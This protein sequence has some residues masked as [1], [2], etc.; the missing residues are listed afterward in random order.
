MT[1]EKEA[2]AEELEEAETR[3]RH[4]KMQLDDMAVKVAEQD[5]TVM[6]LVDELAAE[7]QLRRQEEDA[8]KRSIK[9]VKSSPIDDIAEEDGSK[10]HQQT[11]RGSMASDSGFESEDESSAESVFSLKRHDPTSPCLSLSSASS[12]TWPE[13]YQAESLKITPVRE[14][15]KLRPAV[16]PQRPSTFQKASGLNGSSA[17]G[18][19]IQG[20]DE[21]L[22][23]SCANCQGLKASE[24]WNVVGILKEENKGLKERVGDLEGAVEG[25]LDLVAGL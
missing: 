5:S 24:A 16:P 25:C 4:L 19:S 20:H 8:R 6:N 11:N 7:K 9:L 15:A 1:A 12:T 18:I 21:P 3:A 13:V 23:W 2:Q 17:G 14:A 10:F 22:R